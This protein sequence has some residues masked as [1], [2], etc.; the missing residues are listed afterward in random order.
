M[1]RCLSYSKK[2][3]YQEKAGRSGED[4]VRVNDRDDE[5]SEEKGSLFLLFFA[6]VRIVRLGPGAS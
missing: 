2:C 1:D 5:R 4:G 3:N 6:F